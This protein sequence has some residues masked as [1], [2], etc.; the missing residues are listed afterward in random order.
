[1]HIQRPLPINEVEHTTR[2]I[3]N[4]HLRSIYTFI[5]ALKLSNF[6]RTFLCL[7]A[8]LE[9]NHIQILL[10][11]SWLG[12]HSKHCLKKGRQRAIWIGQIWKRNSYRIL[13]EVKTLL[14]IFVWCRLTW[15]EINLQHLLHF[16][17]KFWV[18]NALFNSFY[19]S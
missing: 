13:I 17:E 2:Y 8:T 12:R 9:R 1:M 10:Q 19:S 16:I 15:W 7:F 3:K 6:F 18:W 11:N 4:K 14:N 5:G